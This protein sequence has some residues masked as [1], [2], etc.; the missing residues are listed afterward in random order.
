MIT[1][2]LVLSEQLECAFSGGVAQDVP[3]L[4]VQSGGALSLGEAF[5]S[6][7]QCG[8]GFFQN[9]TELLCGSCV[10]GKV[11]PVEGLNICQDCF[12]GRFWNASHGI[13]CDLC[14]KGTY[15]N[16]SGAEA[17]LL[18]PKGRFAPGEGAALC[19]PC[20]VGKTTPVSILTGEALTGNDE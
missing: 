18:C 16:N 2:S 3:L 14:Q 7:Q 9:S 1:T 15:Q 4:L 12:P 19:A 6:F 13:E 8:P 20:E 17:C 10:P 11:T 5:V